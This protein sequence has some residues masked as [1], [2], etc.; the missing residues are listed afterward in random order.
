M[1][2]MRYEIWDLRGP[3]SF[4]KSQISKDATRFETYRVKSLISNL[5]SHISKDATTR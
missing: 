5:K 3:I 2:D 4:L 1:W